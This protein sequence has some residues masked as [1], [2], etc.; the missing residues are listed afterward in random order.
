MILQLLYSR[1]NARKKTL[2][3]TAFLTVAAA[4]VIWVIQS[5]SGFQ[6]CAES[7][8]KSYSQISEKKSPPLTLTLSNYASI[9]VRCAGHVFYE[10]RDTATAVATIFI[11]LFTARLWFSTHRLWTV[12]RDTLSH[13][14]ETAERQL[15]AYVF[16]REP[17]ISGL[18]GKGGITL[19]CKLHNFGQTPAYGL[20]CAA[21]SYIGPVPQELVIVRGSIGPVPQLDLGPGAWITIV[22]K[23][24]A[25]SDQ[26]KTDI[27]NGV[28]AIYF[29]GN[30]S[31]CDSF[32]KNHPRIFTL[33]KSKKDGLEGE[34]MAV[35]PKNNQKS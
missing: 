16:P 34:S 4:I 13:A 12:T 14:E 30:F 7:Q 6:A 27:K 1:M 23:H 25:L 15:R 33:M 2:A 22:E 26:E 21:T 24:P 17:K 10:Y 5:S 29:T 3:A 19:T 31:Y 35:A 8:A 9:R 18:F 11:A 20:V 32:K 28:K